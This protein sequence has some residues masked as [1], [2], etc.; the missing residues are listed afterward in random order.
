MTDARRLRWAV[1][2]AAALLAACGT[3]PRPAPQTED[4]MAD[5][6]AETPAGPS[7]EG[8]WFG[9]QAARKAAEEHREAETPGETEPAAESNGPP[10]PKPN[11]PQVVSVPEPDE[12]PGPEDLRGLGAGELETLL[13]APDFRRRDSPAE[14]WQYAGPGCVLDTFLYAG[15]DGALMVKH[16]EARSRSVTRVEPRDC[17]HGILAERKKPEGG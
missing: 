4:E 16:V 13:G 15:E 7:R 3:A 2:F 10:L 14:I 11:G 8:T 1:L 17:Y 6:V 9:D 12:L 5:A